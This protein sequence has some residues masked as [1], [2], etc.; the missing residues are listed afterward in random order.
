MATDLNDLKLPTPSAKDERKHKS[1]NTA[2]HR[3]K[4]QPGRQS[5]NQGST[6][7][8]SNNSS[9]D[10]LSTTAS[11]T[12][13]RSGGDQ[14]LETRSKSYDRHGTNGD[15][16]DAVFGGTDY[17]EDPDAD[18]ELPHDPMAEK[19]QRMHA[20]SRVANGSP[21][22]AQTH[23]KGDSYPPTSA[24]VPSVTDHRERNEVS[25][26][27]ALH[28]LP[29]HAAQRSIYGARTQKSQLHPRT[30]RH[31]SPTA[32]R[33]QE[34]PLVTPRQLQDTKPLD[35][36][37][38]SDFGTSTKSAFGRPPNI[39]NEVAVHTFRP[40]KQAV[41]LRP[42]TPEIKAD[43]ARPRQELGKQATRQAD[44]ATDDHLVSTEKYSYQ[45]GRQSRVAEVQSHHEIHDA[46]AGQALM[47]DQRPASDALTEEDPDER[48]ESQVFREEPLDYDLEELYNKDYASLKG[49]PFDHNPHAQPFVIPGL[50]DTAVL[51]DKLMRLNGA[52][53]QAQA[54][55]FTS[56]NIDEWEEAGDW[57]LDR[58]GETIKRL[59]DVRK[60]KRKAARAFEDEIEVRETAV[61]KKRVLTRAAMV[62][63]KTSG[64]AVLQG[65]PGKKR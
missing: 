16:P 32:P 25:A 17:D 63:M 23:I 20:E 38:Q 28:N 27:G 44:P 14:R 50:P 43:T 33:V 24:G 22:I 18:Q 21:T 8:K 37:P 54:S 4:S 6:F 34:Q 42:H 46:S 62:E 61:S 59:K 36:E 49:E 39:K 35:S 26:S 40:Q 1:K 19:F 48:P 7:Q 52:E 57:F 53:P 3:E 13:R 2:T 9:A 29:T 5:R 47:S 15:Q 51:S 10:N 30:T 56:L 55:F 58:F 45:N 11:T 41:N 12:R 64:A 60:E 31:Q 65:T